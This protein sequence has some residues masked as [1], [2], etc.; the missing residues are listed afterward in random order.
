MFADNGEI[1]GRQLKRQMLLELSP[2]LLLFLSGDILLSGRSGV[3][4]LL[5]GG[6]I[7]ELYLYL[8]QRGFHGGAREE[9]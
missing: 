2:V 3:L 8:L 1:S 9:I 7:L 5:L 4:G 6:G